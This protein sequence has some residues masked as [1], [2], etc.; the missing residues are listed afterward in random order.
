MTQKKKSKEKYLILVDIGILFT[1]QRG[2]KRRVVFL[3]ILDGRD[4]VRPLIRMLHRHRPHHIFSI[5]QHPIDPG[6]DRFFVVLLG[7]DQR[8]EIGILRQ[9]GHLVE[10][11]QL[12]QLHYGPSDIIIRQTIAKFAAKEC[13][14]GTVKNGGYA[15]FGSRFQDLRLRHRDRGRRD[16]KKE[17]RAHPA[18][19]SNFVTDEF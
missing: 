12:A 3:Q 13:G 14:C 8:W 15:G 7:L 18:T 16:D 11:P 9:K 17:L 6:T 19:V 5:I 2:A 4:L 1:A 10:P